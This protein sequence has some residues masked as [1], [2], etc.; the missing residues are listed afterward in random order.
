MTSNHAR[1]PDQRADGALLA[2]VCSGLAQ[3]LGWN[4]WALR[5]LFVIGLFVETIG[6]GLVYLV[7]AFIVPR[8]PGAARRSDE[9]ASPELQTRKERIADLERRF[10]EMERGGR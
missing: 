3:R 5:A 6:T 10:R 4:A 7:L 8:C 1:K 9:L 2:G